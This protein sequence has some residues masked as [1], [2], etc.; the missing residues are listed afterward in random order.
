MVIIKK[1]NNNNNTNVEI[2]IQGYKG[3]GKSIVGVVNQPCH[4]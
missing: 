4:H 1:S 3:L 2:R